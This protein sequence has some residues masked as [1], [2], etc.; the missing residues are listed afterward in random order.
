MMSETTH[1][2]PQLSRVSDIIIPTGSVEY[3]SGSGWSNKGFI[4]PHRVSIQ[5]TG[6]REEAEANVGKAFS[7]LLPMQIEG[8]TNEYIFTFKINDVLWN[9]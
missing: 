6:Y 5:D 1:S 2:R 9:E 8:V 3:Y 4:Q 7:V